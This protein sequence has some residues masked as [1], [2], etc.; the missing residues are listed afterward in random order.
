MPLPSSGGSGGSGTTLTSG[1]ITQTAHGFVVG[2]I[3]GYNGTA[4]VKAQANNAVNAEATGIVT[5]I[6]DANSFTF[7]QSGLITGLSGLTP[8][9]IYFLSDSVAGALTPTEPTAVTSVSKPLLEAVSATSGYYTNMRGTP[10]LGQAAVVQY[11]ENT[12][13]TNLG[14]ITGTLATISGSSFTIPS[15]GTWEVTYNIF[16]SQTSIANGTV[17]IYNSSDVIVPNS[18]GNIASFGNSLVNLEATNKVFIIT[19][20]AATYHLKGQTAAGTM[21]IYNTSTL[22]VNNSGNSKITWL[23]IGASPV[24]M[25]LAGEYVIPQYAVASV[26]PTAGQN[27]A[28]SAVQFM[29]IT[30]PS[31]G[32]WEIDWSVYAALWNGVSAST[33]SHISSALY[34][35]LGNFLV[36]SELVSGAAGLGGVAASSGLFT[37]TRSYP[38]TTTGPAVYNVKVW[39][40]NSNTSAIALFGNGNGRSYISAK[41]IS[42][43]MPATGQTV[44]YVSVKRSTSNQTGIVVN[45]DVIYNSISSGNIP[46]NTTTG[47]FTLTAGK[48]YNLFA[49]SKIRNDGTGSAGRYVQFEW[50]DSVSNTAL[51]GLKQGVSIMS[52]STLNESGTDNAGGI[53]VPVSNQTIKVRVTGADGTN[54]E[55]DVN[56]TSANITQLGSSAVIAGLYPGTW[57]TYTPTITAVTTNPTK[58]TS[59]IVIDTASYIIEGKKL[60]VNYTFW[61]GTAVA[62]GA[63]SGTYKF[64]LPPGI[65]I[66]TTKV[67]TIASVDPTLASP[68]IG[69]ILGTVEM[70]RGSQ[71]S[72]TTKFLGHVYA[73]DANTF[74]AAAMIGT[75]G[76]LAMFDSAIGNA[77]LQSGIGWKMQFTV[78]I[79]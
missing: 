77:A 30:I 50:V 67:T 23:Q 14:T 3:I 33:S 48:T 32:T 69:S 46:Y 74:T 21:T 13:I 10:A 18:T 7:S 38:V 26:T 42:G 64:S 5:S 40:Q 54:I 24:P 34:D 37:G 41:K 78:P 2:N 12:T 51:T 28:A 4:Y 79:V 76:T 65:V 49:S 66:D 11:G 36:N 27:S 71:A 63:G 20:G 9:E 55:L 22:G 60:T 56:R 16:G 62:P 8:G 57:G 61:I 29:S 52:T 44:D 15:A 75:Y 72:L 31:A 59:G 73:A 25:D 45:T 70:N 47:V 43:F 6:I 39:N 1:T 35:N 53:Y 58:P 17:A 68:N 19:S